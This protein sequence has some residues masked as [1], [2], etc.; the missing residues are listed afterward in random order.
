[1]NERL[2]ERE[3]LDKL[4]ARLL[5][6]ERRCVPVRISCFTNLDKFQAAR[7]PTLSAYAPQKG[8]RIEGRS[9]DSDQVIA[10]LTVV[11]ITHCT[12]KDGPYLRVELHQ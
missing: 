2:S 4:E 8:E 10:R 11:Q 3:R 6:V 1:M 12:D 7:W 9:W 5:E